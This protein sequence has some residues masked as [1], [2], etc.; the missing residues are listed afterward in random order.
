MRCAGH[1]EGG[2]HRHR[3]HLRARQKGRP[4]PSRKAD[5]TVEPGQVVLKFDDE[6]TLTVPKA[7]WEMYGHVEARKKVSEVVRPLSR[8]GVE[9]LSFQVEREV[10]I[11]VEAKEAS[12]FEPPED[13]LPLPEPLGSEEVTLVVSIV[14]VAFKD[15]NKWR[16]SDGVRTFYARIRDD[17]FLAR[18]ENGHE[19]F[20]NGDR[21]RC[22][23]RIL[24]TSDAEGLHTEYEVLEVLEHMPRPERPQLRI[25]LPPES[26]S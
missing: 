6:T 7:T 26:P 17:A 15:D 10:T 20:T 4:Q 14:A 22:R 9:R 1:V 8:E 2:H 11:S 21:L 3:R 23:M 18:V 13:A 12:D 16:L 19:S 25:N 24:Q 5:E